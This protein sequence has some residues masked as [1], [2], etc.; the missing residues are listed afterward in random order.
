MGKMSGKAG[1]AV[2]PASPKKPDPADVADPGQ[3]QKG[4][5]S[6]PIKPHKP[7]QTEEE[8]EKKRSWIEIELVGE[9]DKPIPGERYE[10]TLPDGSLARGT[11]DEKG[12]ARVDGIE[13]GTCQVCFPELDKDAWEKA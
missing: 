1:S 13:P 11:L 5:G 8:K 3:V 9:D 7:P 4:Q 12:F 6:T 10:I 2:T